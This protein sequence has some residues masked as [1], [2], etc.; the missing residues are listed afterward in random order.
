[1]ETEN[2]VGY[3]LQREYLRIFRATRVASTVLLLFCG[4][5]CWQQYQTVQGAGEVFEN[6]IMGGKSS[7]PALTQFVLEYGTALA[8]LAGLV[9]FSA[10]AFIWTAR[11]LSPVILATTLGA[12]VSVL[13]GVVIGYA[14][15]TPIQTVLRNFAG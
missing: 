6:M 8:G 12:G 3:D 15:N 13:V 5:W 10:L 9:V 14:V 7:L 11:S 1:M 2:F 4:A